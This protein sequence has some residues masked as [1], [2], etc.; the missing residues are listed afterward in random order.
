MSPVF[1]AR[2][3]FGTSQ[4][5]LCQCLRLDILSGSAQG[6]RIWVKR[7]NDQQ[8]ATRKMFITS[9]KSSLSRRS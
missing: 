2:V 7:G 5:L 1:I 6:L 4:P 3:L 9:M 8:M